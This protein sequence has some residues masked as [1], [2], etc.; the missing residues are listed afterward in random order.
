MVAR[1]WLRESPWNDAWSLANGML[2]SDINYWTSGMRHR[3]ALIAA[4]TFAS[5]VPQMVT[6]P[7]FSVEMKMRPFSF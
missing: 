2:I 5:D 1:F 3:I 6:S 4:F 7:I